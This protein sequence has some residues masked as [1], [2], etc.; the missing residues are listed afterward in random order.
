LLVEQHKLQG[1]EWTNYNNTKKA[2]R[3]QLLDS[4]PRDL[5]EELADPDSDF[6]NV[7][8]L[9]IIT[10]LKSMYG[11]ITSQMLQANFDRL[12][13]A[14]NPTDPINALWRQVKE[15]RDFAVK[16][17]KPIP[18]GTIV[19]L[20]TNNLDLTGVFT[21]DMHNWINK[22]EEIQQDYTQLKTFFNKANKNRINKLKKENSGFA[23]AAITPPPKQP[24]AKPKPSPSPL[25]PPPKNKQ[26]QPT[27]MDV[28]QLQYC[29]THGFNYSHNGHTCKAKC[30]THI[31][32]ATVK[33]MKG[34]NN[35]IQRKRGEKQIHV[36]PVYEKDTKKA[37]TE[38][39][40]DE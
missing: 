19:R 28:G 32:N 34:G 38:A 6:N 14:W 12:S 4:V 10:Y 7:S 11:K 29:F 22:P 23:G 36:P 20:V 39:K 2:L 31:D 8:P 3:K 26:G 25:E 21:L 40:T 24:P 9:Q 15:C 18:D 30:D 13:D 37:K 35:M 1:V 33:N 5:I 16:G 17:G 27:L